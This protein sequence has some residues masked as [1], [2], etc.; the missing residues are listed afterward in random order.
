VLAVAYG[1][2]ADSINDFVQDNQALTDIVAAQGHGTLVEQYFAMS[3]RILALVAAGFA[4]QSTMRI[5]G[6]ETSAHAEQVLATPV[7]RLRFAW[8]H[9]AIAFGGTVAI[10]FVLG[11]AFGVS[12]AVVT[13]DAGTTG[14]A[15]V[16]MLAF[17]PAVW[18]LAGLSMAVIG[19]TPGASALP[20]AFLAVCFV[21]GMF[22]RLLDLPTAVLDLSPFQHVPSYPAADLRALPLAALVVVATGFTVLGLIGIRHRDLG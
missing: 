5:R 11:L 14:Q 19:V 8:S 12:D 3:F 2:I 20:W 21:V 13:G 22:G 7:S 6:E 4:I 1:S 9:L 16:G 10:L 17:V 18:V 15:I